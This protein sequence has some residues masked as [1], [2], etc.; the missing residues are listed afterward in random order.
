LKTNKSKNN[1]DLKTDTRQEQ[2]KEDEII[3]KYEKRSL[4]PNN[5]NNIGNRKQ[6]QND[7]DSYRTLSDDNITDKK[8]R[9]G[10]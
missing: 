10:S 8:I 9:K 7:S 5:K 4:S 3:R 2:N 1:S 6:N